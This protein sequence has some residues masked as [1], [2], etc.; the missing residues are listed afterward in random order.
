M[1]IDDKYQQFDED[2]KLAFNKLSEDSEEWY[3]KVA[4][5]TELCVKEVRE[6]CIGFF[7]HQ[8]KIF[9]HGFYV[10]QGETIP[11]CIKAMLVEE[12]EE[13]FPV[14]NKLVDELALIKELVNDQ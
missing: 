3:C 14:F 11:Q 2:E 5:L 6:S 10:D 1:C 7:Q 8:L 4:Q 12:E 9:A 13:K